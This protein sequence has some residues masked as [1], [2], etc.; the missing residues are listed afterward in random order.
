MGLFSDI[1]KPFKW[2]FGVIAKGAKAEA[3]IAVTITEAVKTILA[4]PAAGFLENIIDSVTGTSIAV[5]AAN[6]VNAIIPKILAAE[7]A[8]EGLPD[9]PTDSDILAFEQRV[10]A[11]FNI[12]S[13]NSRLYTTLGAQIY[14][15][16]QA[17]PDTKFATLVDDIEQ[18]YADYQKDLAGNAA[19]VSATTEATVAVPISALQSEQPAATT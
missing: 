8:I 4:N 10:L 3:P 13:N 7:L 11:A 16:L 6:A 19:A 18:A 1:I 12:K 5:D 15:I 14:G 2:L 17:A 9:S